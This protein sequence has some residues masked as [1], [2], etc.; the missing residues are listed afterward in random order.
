MKA[1]VSLFL[2]TM[3]LLAD[4]PNPDFP[5]LTADEIKEINRRHLEKLRLDEYEC[6]DL[7]DTDSD[8]DLPPSREGEFDL[9]N[10]P[11]HKQVKAIELIEHSHSHSNYPGFFEHNPALE[12]KQHQCQ[13]QPF[14]YSKK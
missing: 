11:F 6:Y 3:T 8:E 5:T 7:P 14:V 13:K 4:Y 1:G 9:E 10:I 2:P 12:P